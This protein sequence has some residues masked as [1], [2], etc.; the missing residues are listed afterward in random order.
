M[1]GKLPRNRAV[2][3]AHVTVDFENFQRVRDLPGQNFSRLIDD[4]ITAYLS[5]LDGAE[6]AVITDATGNR[7]ALVADEVV[8]EAS[9]R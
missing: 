5:L 6:Y 7:M 1:R 3:K 4:F 8:D 9:K 2:H